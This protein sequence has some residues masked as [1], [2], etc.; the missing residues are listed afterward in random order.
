MDNFKKEFELRIDWEILSEFALT[1]QL[2]RT[3]EKTGSSASFFKE[4]LLSEVQEKLTPWLENNQMG[5]IGEN[6]SDFIHFIYGILQRMRTHGAVDHPYLEKY[7]KENL[8]QWALNWKWDNRHFL[9][10]SLGGS[11]QFPKLVGIVHNGKNH[12]MLDMAA[13]RSDNKQSWYSNYF[14]EIFEEP[15]IGKNS[16]LF[17]DF[18]RRLLDTM[19]EVGLLNRED[20]GGGN[21]AI[22][23]K[24]SGSA[25]R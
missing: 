9:N 25:T 16:M 17:N 15:W 14:I 18:M 23:P 7:R 10:K 2:G 22:R 4:E 20:Q 8:N 19:V 1:A 12:E 6:K 11:M 5:H 13:M 24:I 21:Y 3:L